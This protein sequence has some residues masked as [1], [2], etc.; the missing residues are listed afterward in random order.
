MIEY[1][2]RYAQE[3]DIPAIKKYI[4]NNWKKGHILA[5]ENGLFEW[6]YFSNKWDYVIALDSNGIIQGII[7]FI[8][9]DDS[10][11]KDIAISMWKANAGT[12]FLGI[13]LLM[14][15]ME[16]EPHRTLFSPGINMTT[17]GVVYKRMKISTG[18]MNQ[19]YRL[20]KVDEY[21]IAKI[22]DYN[23]PN[24]KNSDIISFVKYNSFSDFI[25]DFDINKYVSKESIPYK[26][27]SYLKRRYFQHP[28]YS[29]VIY[30]LKPDGIS[31]CTVI[32]L[33]VQECNGSKSIR[34]VDCIGNIEALAHSTT[35]FDNLLLQ[36]NAEYIDMY[37][38]GVSDELLRNAGW[39]RLD[40][41]HNIIPNYFSP[42][43]QRNIDVYYCTTN[44]NII[45]FKGD[46]D[47]D[48]PN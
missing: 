20:R 14:Y 19:W 45:L 7:G 27:L 17:S 40:E 30:G 28:S 24:V 32:I 5:Q 33:R 41:T 22:K 4:D 43:E 3:N 44:E 25:T 29:Y 15:L 6:Q 35:F 13:K 34:F 39:I 31:T 42:Y 9:Y 8:S 21:K 48:R 10:P 18:R 47:Q 26:S 16:N 2:I 12:G 11:E 37:E 46:G 23:I 36:E 1:T 38:Q